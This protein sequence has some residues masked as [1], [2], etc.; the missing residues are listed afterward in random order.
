MN[1]SLIVALDRTGV[2]CHK[3]V[4]G[5]MNRSL[6]V[7]FL[8]DLF[9][10]IGNAPCIVLMDNASIH[11]KIEPSEVPGGAPHQLL[12]IPAYTPQ[13]NAAEAAF[14]KIKSRIGKQTS[15]LSDDNI[16]LA[17]IDALLASICPSDVEGWVRE[18]VRWHD[19]AQMRR[20]VGE[21][22][23]TAEAL[24]E[25]RRLMDEVANHADQP[26]PLQTN[27]SPSRRA[28]RAPQRYG[29]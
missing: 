22:H 8:E 17:N 19:V 25:A 16:L 21:H 14:S 6:F 5:R 23:D 10:R 4:R 18:C 28:R 26:V 9:S 12:F 11:K 13:F 2:I 7:E 24:E 1:V 20:P 29:S 27:E 15:E 3:Y